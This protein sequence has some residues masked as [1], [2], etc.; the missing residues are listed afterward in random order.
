M[1]THQTLRQ[2]ELRVRALPLALR[3]L[4]RRPDGAE[5]AIERADELLAELD[6]VLSSCVHGPR[7]GLGWMDDAERSIEL[8]LLVYGLLRPFLA[9][10]GVSEREQLGFEVAARR[11]LRH[12][13]DRLRRARS[14]WPGGQSWPVER[15]VWGWA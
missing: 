2:L 3:C 9:A 10:Q 11:D 5:E 6:V 15:P 4:S 14:R 1:N 8:K 12:S 13:R 7:I